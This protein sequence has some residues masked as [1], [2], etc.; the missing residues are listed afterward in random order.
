MHY[1]EVLDLT[2]PKNVE[3]LRKWDQTEFAYIQILRFIRIT[4]VKPDYFV[5]SR[6]GK[7]YLLST[8][9]NAAPKS[10]MQDNVPTMDVDV[11][12]NGSKPLACR[13]LLNT[14]STTVAVDNPLN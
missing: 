12:D 4:S 9:T 7:H 10:E 2:H 1:A 11:P 13:P 5:V 14:T 8:N 3:L 6:P